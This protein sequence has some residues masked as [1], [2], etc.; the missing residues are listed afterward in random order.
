M[1]SASIRSTPR[2]PFILAI[3]LACGAA[4]AQ[5]RGIEEVSVVGRQLN[6]IGS[7]T[8]ASEGQISQQELDLRPLLRVGEVLETVPGLVA[9]QH[10]GSGKANQFF[11]RGFNLDHGTDF[12]THVD[13]MPVNMRSHGHGQGYTDLNFLIPELVG[14]IEFT[15]GSY[16]AASGDFA[17]AGS[18]RINVAS[19][20]V[21]TRLSL[22]G[23]DFGFRRALLT[24]SA[25]AAGGTFIYGVE[26]QDYAGAWDSIDEDVD[27]KNLW[28]KQ[29]W[30]TAESGFDITFMGYDNTWNSADQIPERAVR[31]G[32]I[33][34]LGSVDT[35]VGGESS[36][37]S[38]SSSWRGSNA[39]GAVR[40]SAYEIDYDMNLYSNFS[41]FIEPDGDQFQQ[42]DD[43]KLFG[44]QVEQDLDFELGSVRLSNTFGAQLRTDTID[45]V[46]LRSTREREFLGDIRFDSVD[47]SSVSTYWQSEAQWT[48]SLRSTT[49]LRYDRFDFDVTSL[50]AADPTT[51]AANSGRKNDS[52][53]S[54]SLGL[55]YTVDDSLE[56][57]AN[58]GQG[59]HSNDARGVISR[60]DPVS[61]EAIDAA[62]PLVKTL[63]SEIGARLFLTER[64]NA[65]VVLWQLDIDSELLFV[66]D[67]G[68]TEDTGV[69]SERHG[70]ELTGYYQIGNSWSVDLEYAYANSRFETPIDG[71]DDIPGALEH[72]VSGGIGFQR[73]D[74]FHGYLR[75]RHFGD[76]NLD[77]GVDAE[78]STLLN[79]RLGYA[80][81]D[82]LSIT[83]DALNM[84]DSNDRDIQYFYESQLRGEPAPVEDRH[85]HVFEPRAIRAYLEY[86]F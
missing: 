7:A 45:G 81:N 38:L 67:A 21:D 69:G 75:L 33:S 3:G 44:G 16:D 59:F 73:G 80:F 41:Y 49:S 79:A 58:I 10:S 83:I 53:V 12:A 17:G 66:G 20:P 27:R 46:G 5:E 52:V 42:L 60:L 13:G 72:V 70:L 82:R 76:Y 43:R 25:D 14:S 74:G 30:G 9:T 4:Q 84:L 78:G 32:L 40:A 48:Q 18:A 19:R 47:Q 24:G 15:K 68:N 57:Y 31:S 63:G 62:D 56:L 6:L 11:L 34:D 1:N 50:A 36:R 23:G 39:L 65:S 64:L 55:I 77:G 2:L 29:S 51:L 71:F 26:Q 86:T 54:G 35:T 8:S 28:L 22:G 85:F 37:Y 61:A